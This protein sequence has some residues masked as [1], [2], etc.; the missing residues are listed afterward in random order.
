MCI[1][2]VFLLTQLFNLGK[3]VHP[4]AKGKKPKNCKYFD[5]VL[6]NFVVC[7]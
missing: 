4:L 3:E 2:F 5:F 7:V 6:P 1:I